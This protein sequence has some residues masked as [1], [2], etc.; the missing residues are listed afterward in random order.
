M[1]RIVTC[2]D[3]YRRRRDAEVV[4]PVVLDEEGAVFP[5]NIQDFFPPAGGPLRTGGLA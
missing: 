5:D 4:G 3:G 2:G 1:A